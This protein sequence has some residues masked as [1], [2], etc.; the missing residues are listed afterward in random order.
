MWSWRVPPADR[1]LP[2][3]LIRLDLVGQQEGVVDEQVE[4]SLLAVH[5]FEGA[6]DGVVA[7]MVTD[8]PD[9]PSAQRMGLRLE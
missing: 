7:A 4:A 5:A 2:E 1:C 6:G 8:H 3:G 9:D